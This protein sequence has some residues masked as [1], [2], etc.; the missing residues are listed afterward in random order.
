MIRTLFKVLFVGGFILGLT[1][2]LGLFVMSN[3]ARIDGVA[4]TAVPNESYLSSL[5]ERAD[6]SDAYRIPMEF[7]PFGK[8]DDVADH[9]FEKGS[10]EIRRSD[11]EVVYRGEA[12]GLHYDISYLLERRT[13]PAT[14]TVCTTVRYDDRKGRIYFTLVKPIH[15]MLMPYLLKRMSNATVN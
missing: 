7:N 13:Q 5:A 3:L 4:P 12:P 9:A 6:Y 11:D 14:L 15:K 2:L 1:A 8:V 10:A